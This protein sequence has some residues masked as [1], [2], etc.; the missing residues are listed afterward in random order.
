MNMFVPLSA[1][2]SPYF[3]N[4]RKIF[5]TLAGNEEMSLPALS[6]RRAPIGSAPDV[7]PA[8]C[9]AGNTYPFVGSTVTRKA[10]RISSGPNTSSYRTRPGRIARPAASAEVQ[11]SGRRLFVF[12]SKNAP[13][14]AS[15][16]VPS[17]Q[18]L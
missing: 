3:L 5:C 10:W 6:R 9:D 16:F 1:T 14:A 11:V 15:Q 2:M 4:A 13:D 8:S 12:M 17:N 18:T 7:E